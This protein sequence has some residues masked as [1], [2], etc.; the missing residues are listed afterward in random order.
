VPKVVPDGKQPMP[1]YKG[2]MTDKELEDVIAYI[3]TSPSEEPTRPQRAIVSFRGEAC[4][5]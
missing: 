4:E 3:R 1:G 2:K 5:S